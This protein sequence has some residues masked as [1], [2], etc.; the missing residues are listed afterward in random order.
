MNRILVLSTLFLCSTLLRL[1]AQEEVYEL[2]TYELEFLRP[3]EV[4]HNYLEHALIPAL[5]RQG[6]RHVGAFEEAGDALPKKIYLLIAYDDIQAFQDSKEALEEDATY[7]ED[8]GAYLTADPQTMP[9]KRITSNLIQSTTGFP[10]LASPESG[11]GLFELRIYES[12]NEDAL[13]RKVKMFN[14]SEFDIFEDV[15][16][17]MVFF[18]ANIAG[19]QMPCLTYMLAFRDREHHAAAWARFGPHPE[20]QRISKLEEY[21]HAM[22]DITRVFLKPL[23]Y[24]SL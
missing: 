17:P 2:R 11:T 5:G 6:V 4:L 1:A 9:Y 24:S 15:G 3:A 18:G 16:L 23:P 13:R 10:Q 7:L 8:A 20:W 21:A 12:Y 14:D 22:D 19:E